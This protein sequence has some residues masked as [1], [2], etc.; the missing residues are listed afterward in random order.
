[1]KS[2]IWSSLVLVSIGAMASQNAPEDSQQLSKPYSILAYPDF[3]ELK[4]LPQVRVPVTTTQVT[5]VVNTTSASSPIDVVPDTNTVSEKPF[6]LENLDLSG[7][8]PEIARKVAS[9]INKT[10]PS[11]IPSNS[12][13][14]ALEDN[15]ARYRGRLPALNLQTHMYSSDAQ[16]RWVKING[17]ELKEGDRLNNIQLLAIEP[18][19]ITIRFDN[20]IIDIPALYE[21]GG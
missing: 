2:L 14:I 5:Q 11:L 4:P 21:W 3:S 9:A 20:D 13:H 7:L 15:Q 1:M 12:D 16:R 18:Q 6:D 19:F 10:E 17:Q 8:D